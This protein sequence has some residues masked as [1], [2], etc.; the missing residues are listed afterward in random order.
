[1]RYYQLLVYAGDIN[2]LGKN[3]NIINTNI[4]NLSHSNKKLCPVV[5]IE[6]TK[7]VFLSHP[8]NAG[9]HNIKK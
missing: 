2:L 9:H 1:M 3:K 5:Y 7:Y 6:K 8:E 4:K